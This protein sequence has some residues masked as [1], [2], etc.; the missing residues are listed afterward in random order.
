[1]SRIFGVSYH[2]LGARA[3]LTL[4]GRVKVIANPDQYPN[5]SVVRLRQ[6]IWGLSRGGSHRVHEC[7]PSRVIHV[8]L[9]RLRHGQL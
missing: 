2:R 8:Q 9:M 1:M 7:T 6:G 5:L 4:V 3:G